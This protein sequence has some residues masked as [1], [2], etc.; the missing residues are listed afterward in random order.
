MAVNPQQ[1]AC[2]PTLA[3]IW[4]HTWPGDAREDLDHFQEFDSGGSLE[5][6]DR[7]SELP[8]SPVNFGDEGSSPDDQS[9]TN[10][11]EGGME[12]VSSTRY[13]NN[14]YSPHLFSDVIEVESS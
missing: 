9:G 13:V 1:R 3:S 5:E 11:D 8:L 7:V 12:S 4:T 10:D 2:I 14:V 6:W